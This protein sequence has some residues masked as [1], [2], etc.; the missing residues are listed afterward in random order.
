MRSTDMDTGELKI[1]HPEFFSK[2][3]CVNRASSASVVANPEYSDEDDKAIEQWLRQ[4]IGSCWHSSGTA[5]MASK[6]EMG[7]VDSQLS[8]YG[9]QG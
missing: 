6:E 9:V 5:K 1:A 4:N 3:A 2:A 7:V 8:V